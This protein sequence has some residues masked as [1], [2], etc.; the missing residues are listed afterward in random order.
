MTTHPLRR[1]LAAAAFVL[2]T[3]L[4]GLAASD[5]LPAIHGAVS[6]TGAYSDR[7][8]F[9]G[10]TNGNADIN[11]VEGIVNGSYRFENG[12]RTSAQLYSY[13]LDD[14]SDVALDFANIDYSFAPQFGVR[15][16]RLKRASG[17]YGDSQDI[18]VLRPFAFLP[19]DA[20]SKTL[21]PITAALDGAAI[22]GN[23][24]LGRA[25]SLNYQLGYGTLPTI[26]PESPYVQGVTQGGLY[27]TSR[28][29]AD[30]IGVFALAWN[31]P[32]DGLRL[33]FTA[34]RTYGLSLGGPMRTAAQLA[35]SPSNNRLVPRNFPP[36]VWD[37]LVAGREGSL[38]GDID[39]FTYSAEYTRGDWQFSAEYVLN[40]NDLIVRMPAPLGTSA[41]KSKNDAYF[42][43]TTWQ[44]T[45]KYQVGAY[46]A[47][48][49]GSKSDRKGTKIT[50]VPSHTG[51][52]KD[53]ALANSYALTSWSLVKAEVHL[54]DGTR[55]LSAAANGDARN[56]KSNWTY[57]VLKTTVS[58]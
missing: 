4:L 34:N 42:F 25:G 48:S 13:K 3:P 29:E 54:L 26:D 9:L 20:Y 28:I 31:L 46:Y 5:K 6:V 39:R 21:R 40:A 10:N 57:F 27:N 12:I 38:D 36:G 44:A 14:Y 18:D 19:L 58:F 16:G 41:S 24:G 47:E 52:L 53:F 33:L 1:R 37:A 49:F 56:W 35:T 45:P 17:L 11:I 22:Y 7:Y 30:N 43:M 15:A 32:V 51:Y 8:N 50:A 55:G 23:I 2:A